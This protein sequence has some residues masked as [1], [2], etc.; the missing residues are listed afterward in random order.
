MRTTRVYRSLGFTR[1][2]ISVNLNASLT[3]FDI[4]CFSHFLCLS[5]QECTPS[6]HTSLRL[7]PPVLRDAAHTLQHTICTFDIGN[8]GTRTNTHYTGPN[9]TCGER[10][11]G[12]GPAPC[13]DPDGANSYLRDFLWPALLRSGWSVPGGKFTTPRND[14]VNVSTIRASS[15][16]YSAANYLVTSISLAPFILDTGMAD[17]C[18]S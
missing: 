1:C 11:N 7:H 5:L 10:P 9:R 2:R 16:F 6:C 14:W 3:Q 8:W 15:F 18:V 17:A 4:S 12:A 13:P